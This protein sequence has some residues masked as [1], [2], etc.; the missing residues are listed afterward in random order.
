MLQ[1]ISF[2]VIT[3]ALTTSYTFAQINN[4]A[5]PNTNFPFDV[6]LTSPDSTRIT[7]SLN[8]LNNQHK[9]TLLVFWLT[10]CF[11]CATELET[12]AQHYEVWQEKY[13]LKII[14]ISLDFP[15]RFRQIEQRL[16]Q[17]KYPFEVWWDGGRAFKS[18]LPGGLNGF[19]QAFL[20]NKSGQL[21]WQHKGFR[22]G[23]E[24][25][26]IQAVQQR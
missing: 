17:K 1:K 21:C 14:A 18:I 22:P 24:T 5:Q 4:V 25:K 10:T 20:F 3:F 11:P 7:S 13:D 12:Y 9:A 19:P 6:K 2:L 26:L 16:Q 8:V 23:D 15:D